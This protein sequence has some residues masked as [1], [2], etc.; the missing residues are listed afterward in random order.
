[1][2]GDIGSS[3]LTKV[4]EY[5]VAPVGRQFKYLLY[6]NSNIEDLNDQ[7]IDL[8]NMRAG[9]Q[10]SVNAAQ[11]NVEVIGSDV[12]AW[13]N[14][15]ENIKKEAN[16]ILEGRDKVKNSPWWSPNLRQRYVLGRKA[17]KK[18]EVVTKLQGKGNKYTKL[19]YPTPP[20]EIISALTNNSVGFESRISTTKNIIKAM[21]DDEISI[22]GICGM[23]GVGKTT[24]AKEVR[25]ILKVENI[26]HESFIVVVSQSLDIKKIQGQLAEKLDLHFWE[27]TIP[28][29][30][31]KLRARLSTGLK[32]LIIFDDVWEGLDLNE[33]GIPLGGVN[34]CKIIL[35]SR[36]EN[37]CLAMGSQRNFTVQVLMAQ[38]AWN[39]FKD[40]AGDCVDT[41]DLHSIAKE[42]VR[43]CGGLPI[44]I[45]TLGKA[46]KYR[47]KHAWDDVLQQ[48]QKCSI[49]NIP[50]MENKVYASIELSYKYLKGNQARSLL[51]LCCLFPE[52]ED[53]PNEYLVRY[54]VGLRLFN[55]VETLTESRNRVETLLDEL[56]SCFLLLDVGEG[57]VK[58][59]DVVRDACLLIASKGEH[60]YMV[61]QDN[62]LQEW[63]KNDSYQ[64]YTAI[65]LMSDEVQVLATGL[66]C[67]QLKL[68]RLICGQGSLNVSRDFFQGM[69][70][71]D[72]FD[73][74]GVLTESLPPSLQFLR[75]LRTLCLNFCYIRSDI[76][77]IGSLKKLKILS[78][79]GSKL[80]IGMLP[81]EIGKLSNLRLLD[82]RCTYGPCRIP[83]IVFSSLNKLEELYVGYY[84]RKSDIS[85][86]DHAII[87]NLN[88][89]SSLKT[90]QIWLPHELLRSIHKTC[91]NNLT[92]F[93]LSVYREDMRQSSTMLRNVWGHQF[94]NKVMLDRMF[95]QDLHATKVCALLRQ[96]EVLYLRVPDLKN[97]VK[98]LEQEGF[99]KLRTLQ[100]SSCSEV[101]YLL[102][103]KGSI[104]RSTFINLEELELEGMDSLR[105]ICYG[106]LPAESF[107][108]LEVVRLN[109]LP[110]LGHLWKA[111]IQPPA[112]SNLK[113][114]TIRYCGA[115][116]SLFQ[117]SVAKCLVQIEDLNVFSCNMMKELVS[118]ESGDEHSEKIEFP[119]LKF[120]MLSDLPKLRTFY[121]DSAIDKQPFLNQQVLL[122]SM[123]TL[124]IAA[125]D[126]LV[127]IFGAQVQTGSLHKLRVMRLNNCDKL[128]NVAVSDSIRVL[129]NLVELE[130]KFCSSLESV[131]DFEGLRVLEEDAQAMLSQLE[132]LK[133]SNLS[134]LSDICKK[135]PK[136]TQCF[137][138]LR[139]L[140]I[141]CCNSLR[142]LLS[143]ALAKLLLNLQNI[144]LK[145]CEMIEEI[146]TGEEGSS[147]TCVMSGVVFPQLRILELEDLNNLRL[148]CASTHNFEF[149][150]LDKVL[151]R[152]CPSMNT[153]CSGLVSAPK[154][155]QLNVGNDQRVR[156]DNLNNAIHRMKE[157]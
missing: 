78:F 118:E 125:L 150:L 152:N 1:M 79:F 48:L 132:T 126:N 10:L 40:M 137:Q 58:M 154:L 95:M 108:R 90:L 94:Q 55:D 93:E 47:K 136:E 20:T 134:L 101:K 60:K 12:E 127:Q 100:M 22:I 8:E 147:E 77:L 114:L 130:V 65:S 73:F 84:F 135:V 144:R 122:P 140:H 62:K 18:T 110:A 5:M 45:V 146:I 151:I 43:E 71:L 69:N 15:V 36:D 142:Y 86:E 128:L 32:S 34:K 74:K 3:F 157:K 111:P 4:A 54:W 19:S 121:P 67:P 81:T 104:P 105:E 123:E 13:L 57:Y 41:S 143:Y 61:R 89:L 113:F 129:P 87:S 109:D 42:V 153:F 35:T 23:G 76:A 80:D 31:D 53:I 141:D 149:P 27:T 96:T 155:D 145:E 64:P 156:M 72:V 37:V 119:K 9:V 91:F 70:R 116:S 52:D 131:F 82:L 29:R 59:H 68:L 66:D 38:E 117:K 6:S 139:S 88:L 26:F 138:N 46:L 11:R 75:N 102:D 56:K 120:L 148:F 133:L 50:E 112:L 30:A 106:N 14:E 17:T 103:A 49:T 33:V 21:K 85:Y 98:E 115:I 39:L 2:A 51:L 124:D 92:R 25:E 63:P 97:L 107:G 16:R 28:G 7:V 83:S 99:V 24:M 44:A